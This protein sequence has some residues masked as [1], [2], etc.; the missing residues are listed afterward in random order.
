MRLFS[1]KQL[2]ISIKLIIDKVAINCSVASPLSIFF[3]SFC[4]SHLVTGPLSPVMFVL[5]L[6]YND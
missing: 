4:V 1:T 5:N 6:L 2:A 3:S